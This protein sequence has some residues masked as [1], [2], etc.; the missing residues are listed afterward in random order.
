MGAET[1]NHPFCAAFTSGV[2]EVG[3]AG[4]R[5]RLF[6]ETRAAGGIGLIVVESAHVHGTSINTD[7]MLLA[8]RLTRR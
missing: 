7:L 6:H 8:A 3:R 2:A 5:L 1:K 4:D